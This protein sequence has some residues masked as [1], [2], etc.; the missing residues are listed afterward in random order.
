M[1]L[2]ILV[3]LIFLAAI[4]HFL[5]KP[6][7]A[8]EGEGPVHNYQPSSGMGAAG[9]ALTIQTSAAF[10]CDDRDDYQRALRMLVNNDTEAFKS[11]IVVKASAG[12]CTVFQ[13][14]E[15]VYLDDSAI[16][17]GLVKVRRQGGLVSYWT[18]T[19]HAR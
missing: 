14:G 4:V 16:L 17:S 19:E 5:T 18:A 10:G 3:G 6:R 2:Y 9:S 13:A 7:A 15:K 1:R 8:A 11:F 12:D